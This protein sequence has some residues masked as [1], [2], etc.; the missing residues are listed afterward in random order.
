MFKVSAGQFEYII[1]QTPQGVLGQFL[2]VVLISP[3][4]LSTGFPELNLYLWDGCATLLIAYRYLSYRRWY[5]GRD[6][7]TAPVSQAIL[8]HYVAPVLFLGILWALLFAKVLQQPSTEMHLLAMVFGMGLSAAATVTLGAAF[9]V[10]IAFAAPILL[11]LAGTFLANGTQIHITAALFLLVGTAFALYTARKYSHHFAL[12]Q[13]ATEQLRETEMEAL[14]CLGKA[15]EYRDSDTGDHVLR[16]G[17]ASYVLAR[18]AGFSE[19][20]AR[21]LMYA[22]PLHDLGKIGIRDDVLL[23]P[24]KLT[25]AEIEEMKRHTQIGAEI[26]KNSKSPVMQMARKVALSHHE[27]WDGSGYPA[28][29][30]GKN[31][32]IEGRIVAICDVFDALI[33]SRPYK[34][35]WTDTEAITHLRQNAGTHFDPTLVALF[36]NEIPKIKEFTLRLEVHESAT[37]LHPLVQLT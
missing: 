20:D 13:E 37:G 15:G 34:H 16:V 9:G 10:Y 5:R 30:A 23:K 29:L 28:G 27:K 35:R 1:S 32:P 3:L 7:S 36:I 8:L 4:L 2:G 24:G 31:I 26:L 17:Y 6:F 18:A 25:D 19:T 33:S 21:N 14:I 12:M 22:S 11:T